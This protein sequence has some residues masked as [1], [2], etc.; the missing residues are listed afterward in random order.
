MT[1]GCSGAACGLT[2]PLK[3]PVHEDTCATAALLTL[4]VPAVTTSTGGDESIALEGLLAGATY[5]VEVWLDVDTS[6]TLSTGDAIASGGGQTVVADGSS[7]M[8]F[9]LDALQP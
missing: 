2:G 6:G 9:T 4:S 3:V 1:V 5:C 8:G 7:E